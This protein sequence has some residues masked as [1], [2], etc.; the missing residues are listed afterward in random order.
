MYYEAPDA[1]RSSH[2]YSEIAYEIG[3]P[4]ERFWGRR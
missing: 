2:I 4:R 3:C 1:E